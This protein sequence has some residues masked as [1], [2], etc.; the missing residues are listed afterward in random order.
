MK[1]LSSLS[2][3]ELIALLNKKDEEI[4]DVLN[5]L[6]SANNELSFVKGELV[7]TKEELEVLRVSNRELNEKIND[8]IKKYEEKTEL[9]RKLIID[10]Y[11]PKSEKLKDIV[12]NELEETLS[13]NK[14]KANYIKIN[15]N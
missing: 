13:D 5:E 10:T 1:D 14:K 12:I 11:T 15:S 9:N 7:Q 6:S 8:L 2:K 4:K 3:E